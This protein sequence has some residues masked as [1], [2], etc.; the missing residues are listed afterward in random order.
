V[1]YY[2]LSCL[3]GCLF[4]LLT[5]ESLD[6]Q[7]SFSGT[8]VH[9][10][11]GQVS[12]SWGQVQGHTSASKYT[13]LFVGGLPCL[14]QQAARKA[15]SFSAMTFC[16]QRKKSAEHLDDKQQFLKI[17]IMANDKLLSFLAMEFADDYGQIIFFFRTNTMT[18]W[19]WRSQPLTTI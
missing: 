11:Q 17:D 7:T 9:L 13:H 4:G 12:R 8:E 19:H 15:S 6:P 16:T 10:N 18:V 1:W 3:C 2:F 5:L 14:L